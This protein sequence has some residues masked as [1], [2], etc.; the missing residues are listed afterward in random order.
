[1]QTNE[2]TAIAVVSGV[3]LVPLVYNGVRVI[4]SE[5]LAELYDTTSKIISFNF[6]SNKTKYIA[7]L[8]YFLLDGEEMKSFRDE[9]GLPKNTRCIYL[10]TESGALLH[11]KS[12]RSDRAWDIYN[13]LVNAYFRLR[14]V[15]TCEQVYG[16]LTNLIG[17]AVSKIN[18]LTRENTRLKLMAAIDREQQS[19]LQAIVKRKI[20]E[21]VGGDEQKYKVIAPALNSAV[22]AVYRRKFHLDSF[23]NTPQYLFDEAVEFL[24]NWKPSQ[25]HRNK[26]E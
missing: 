4:M 16:D 19:R 7:G 13:E 24:E 15:A 2:N 6:N 26:R 18:E 21:S 8:H 14:E 5:Q 3:N 9:H 20:L 22:W 25:K 12:I 17:M 10:W 11:A 1:M 23:R